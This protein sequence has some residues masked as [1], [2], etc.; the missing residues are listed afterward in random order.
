MVQL[1]CPGCPERD[2]RIAQLEATV[3]ELTMRLGINATNSQSDSVI[4]E[5]QVFADSPP[6]SA[7][8]EL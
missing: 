2:E 3:R 6:R 7:P 4:W 5:G 8:S 1:R